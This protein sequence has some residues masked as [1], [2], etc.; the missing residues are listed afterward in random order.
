M[1]AFVYLGGDCS[2]VGLK[3]CFERFEIGVWII[4]IGGG[5]GAR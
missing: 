5:G 1:Y 4:I 3:D 2:T